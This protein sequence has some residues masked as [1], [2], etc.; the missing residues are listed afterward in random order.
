MAAAEGGLDRHP[1]PN[2][3]RGDPAMCMPDGLVR[4]GGVQMS[5]KTARHGDEIQQNRRQHDRGAMG[6]RRPDL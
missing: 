6:V 3:G 2:R 1:Q 4:Y 5:A